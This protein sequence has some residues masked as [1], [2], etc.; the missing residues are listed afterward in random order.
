MQSLTNLWKSSIIGKLVLLAAIF[1][2]FCLCIGFISVLNNPSTAGVA[3]TNTPAPQET[4]P[5]GEPTSTPAPTDLPLPTA[6]ATSEPLGETRDQPYPANAVVDLGDDTQ[7][8]IVGIVRPANDAVL[9]ANQFNEEPEPGLEYAMLR[10]LV[11]CNKSTND[12]CSF[13][14]YG[15]HVV[16]AD[17]TV[18][19]LAFVAGLTDELDASTEFFGGSSIEGNVVFLVPQGDPSAVLYYEPLF[20]GSPIYIA[21][22][23]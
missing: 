4:T 5:P 9:Q 12:K 13:S 18:H 11:E 6:T 3:A 23:Q 14:T 22:P 7:M 1:M 15:L 16:G 19:D 21:L 2:G 20:I 8:S 10:L 17:G